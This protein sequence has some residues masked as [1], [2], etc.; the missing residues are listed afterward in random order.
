MPPVNNISNTKLKMKTRL[1]L[2]ICIVAIILSHDRTTCIAAEGGNH[3]LHARYPFRDVNKHHVLD[4]KILGNFRPEDVPSEFDLNFTAAE[5]ETQWISRIKENWHKLQD[6]PDGREKFEKWI[7]SRGADGCPMIVRAAA[8]G[9]HEISLQMIPFTD[10]LDKTNALEAALNH[11]HL[12]MAQEL[13]SESS[14]PE[15]I[16]RS[17]RNLSTLCQQRNETISSFWL[18]WGY[19]E[20]HVRSTCQSQ[21]SSS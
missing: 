18:V 9:Y 19:R 13:M 1:L 2:N 3:F 12:K 14:N 16:N 5:N 10:C 21:R 11:G 17:D 8:L 6:L 20:A 15:H 7:Q 4:N